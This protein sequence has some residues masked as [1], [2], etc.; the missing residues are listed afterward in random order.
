MS[1]MDKTV[2]V[3][4]EAINI[5]AGR[6]ADALNRLFSTHIE[7]RVPRVVMRSTSDPVG[8]RFPAPAQGLRVR[9]Q[10]HGEVCGTAQLLLDYATAQPILALLGQQLPPREMSELARSIFTEM[11]NIIV[12]AIIG[13]ISNLVQA[14]V[15]YALPVIESL[16]ELLAVHEPPPGL[17]VEAL[18]NFSFSSSD[19][20]IPTTLWFA[21]SRFA[22]TIATRLHVTPADR[23]AEP[24][25]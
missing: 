9:M 13:A 10:F 17:I 22:D 12:N 11:S 3:L 18:V 24:S 23:G 6:A 8:E 25:E 5:G 4:T 15:T 20:T 1:D 14:Q 7:L 2:D 19:C 21:D 16:E